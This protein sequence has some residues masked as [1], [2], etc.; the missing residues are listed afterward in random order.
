M[1]TFQFI[2][3]ALR[4]I[5]KLTAFRYPQKKISLMA[6]YLPVT[7]ISSYG[8]ALL[9]ERFIAYPKYRLA[10]TILAHKIAQQ[11]IGNI[12]T[13]ENWKHICLQ[14]GISDFLVV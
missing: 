9:D 5:S 6:T 12:V 1:R 8:L 3:K 7:S 4:I 2:F 13:I 14:V 10:H 11:W